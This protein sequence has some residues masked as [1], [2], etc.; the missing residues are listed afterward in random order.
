MEASH[1]R[2][3]VKDGAQG[4]AAAFAHFDFAA[5]LPLCERGAPCRHRPGLEGTAT[6]KAAQ[7]A[8]Q[9]SGHR[10]DP[11]DSLD[12]VFQARKDFLNVG[13]E[14]GQLLLE[15]LQLRDHGADEQ[16]EGM[17]LTATSQA[18]LG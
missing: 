15:K 1:A 3:L 13:I 14:F 18:S 17:I 10:A 9:R 4:N 11:G 8:E 7:I 2:G 12:G 5:P 16:I 6:C